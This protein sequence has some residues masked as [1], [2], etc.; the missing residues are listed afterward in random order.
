MTLRNRLTLTFLVMVALLLAVFAVAIYAFS[1]DF[2][3]SEFEIRLKD[4]ARTTATLLLEIDEVDEALLRTIDRNNLNSLNREHVTV[5][6]KDMRLLYDSDEKPDEHL[7][8]ADAIIQVLKGADY[9]FN[10]GEIQAV[11]LLFQFSNQQYIL[12]ASAYDKYGLNKLYYLRNVLIASYFGSLT[13]IGLLGLLFS[14]RAT[15]PLLTIVHQIDQITAANLSQRL[16]ETGRQDEL[17]RLAIKFNRMLDRLQDSFNFQ[18]QFVSHASHELRTPLTSLKGQISVELLRERSVEEY[19][20]TLASL[21]EDIDNLTQLIN[22]LL[23]LSMAS[24]D[25]ANLNLQPVELD[26]AL[27]AVYDQ[28]KTL[29]PDYQ[30]SLELP[31]ED[32]RFIVNG[33][34]AL[35]KSAMLNLLDNACKYSSNKTARVLLQQED[36]QLKLSVINQADSLTVEDEKHIFEPFYRGANSGKVKGLGIG[37]PLTKRII[38]VHGGH[39]AAFS[40]SGL[41]Q[42]SV[43]LP[44]LTE[45]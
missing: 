1:A 16:P 13:I 41:T 27:F 12:I 19:K 18:K 32:Q 44:V 37:L 36:H 28:L 10:V 17:D 8:P 21:G 29:H 11:A 6:S 42:F 22:S 33:N 45:A 7:L 23:D 40:N 30:I 15:R 35:L 25:V 2:R 14:G 5:Y 43:S 3:Q 9:H 31:D 26:L 20:K 34:E 4:K 39:I 38:D 24:Q